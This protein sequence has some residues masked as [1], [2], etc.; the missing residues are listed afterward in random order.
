M[1][2][3]EL[4]NYRSYARSARLLLSPVGLWPLEKYILAC[5]LM[6]TYVGLSLLLLNYKFLDYN[7]LNVTDIHGVTRSFSW[8][9]NMWTMIIKVIP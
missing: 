9:I 2:S 3:K 7:F 4:A 6:P 1:T 5:R 8:C